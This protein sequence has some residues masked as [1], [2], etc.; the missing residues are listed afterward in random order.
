MLA[1]FIHNHH[2][3]LQMNVRVARIILSRTHLVL[4]EINIHSFYPI[5]QCILFPRGTIAPDLFGGLIRTHQGLN[6][7][8]GN[9]QGSSGMQRS[10]S[11]ST[12]RLMGTQPRSGRQVGKGRTPSQQLIPPNPQ[13]LKASHCDQGWQPQRDKQNED[14]QKKQSQ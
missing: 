10:A 4:R 5:G 13:A 8:E 2:L 6:R 14:E 7:L 1:I 11:G 9:R 3:F 12:A